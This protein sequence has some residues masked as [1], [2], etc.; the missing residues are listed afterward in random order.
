MDTHGGPYDR[1]PY[2]RDASGQE[3]ADPGYEGNPY[4]PQSGYP[5]SP[6]DPTGAYGSPSYG[7]QG[8]GEAGYDG[9]NPYAPD[10]TGRMNR[11]GYDPGYRPD[12]YAQADM[13]V[14]TSAIPASARYEAV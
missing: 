9:S 5:Q 3:G 12:G 10:N 13:A 6:Y 7:Q 4:G 8:Y 14:L 1:D 11:D 2:G